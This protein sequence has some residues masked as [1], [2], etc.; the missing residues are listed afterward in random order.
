MTKDRLDIKSSTALLESSN[1]KWHVI[2]RLA[3]GLL[4]ET[5]DI[6]RYDAKRFLGLL[7]EQGYKIFN[8]KKGGAII[9]CS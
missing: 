3:G 5:K 6:N 9:E 4:Q 8:T 1:D 7:G 2:Y